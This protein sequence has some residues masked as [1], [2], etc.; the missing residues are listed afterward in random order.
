MK[1]SMSILDLFA[2]FFRRKQ[3]GQVL[4]V[5]T[6]MALV[7]G[8][9]AGLA[10][11]FGDMYLEKAR[12][13]RAVDSLGLRLAGNLPSTTAAQAQSA[14]EIMRA[15][16]PGFMAEYNPGTGYSTT[17]SGAGQTT[18]TMSDSI[19]TLVV[20]VNSAVNNSVNPPLKIVEV[21]AQASR[22]HNTYFLGLAGI[23]Q[24]SLSEKATAERVPC[25]IVLI[26][27]VSG[28]MLGN[29]GSTALPIAVKNFVASFQATEDKD[30]L[31]VVTFS[32]Y[33]KCMWPTN[34]LASPTNLIMAS[35]YFIT[36]VTAFMTNPV[37]SGGIRFTGITCAQEGLRLA[38]KVVDNMLGSISNATLRGKLKVYYI[39]FTDGDFNTTRAY[40]QGTG[41][42]T[43]HPSNSIPWFHSDLPLAC[44][45]MNFAPYT[46][47]Q[48]AN[49][50]NN[51][52]GTTT[53]NLNTTNRFGNYGTVVSNGVSISINTTWTN[54]AGVSATIMASESKSG[55]WQNINDPGAW[56]WPA[57]VPIGNNANGYPGGNSGNYLRT[58]NIWTSTNTTTNGMTN[59][60]LWSNNSS[61]NGSI[62]WQNLLFTN[63]FRATNTPIFTNTNHNMLWWVAVAENFKHAYDF[64]TFVPTP[65][66]W[67]THNPTRHASYPTNS[68]NRNMGTPFI[69][70]YPG[71]R[72]YANIYGIYSGNAT[73]TRAPSD[74]NEHYGTYPYAS[75]R[76]SDYYPSF[77]FGSNPTNILTVTNTTTNYAQL[78]NYTKT[79]GPTL[80]MYSF[81]TGSTTNFTYDSANFPNKN[82]YT[83]I[84][85]EGYWISMM[86][87]WIARNEQNAKIYFVNFSDNN[88]LTEKRNIANDRTGSNGVNVTPFFTGQPSGAFYSTS[89]QA[90]LTAAF[91][92]I[93][94]KI[95]TQL[96]Q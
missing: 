61:T 85:D 53:Y 95:G 68:P 60:S 26:L 46:S 25:I 2:S 79:N 88:R 31:A 75:A 62:A 59:T 7:L 58:A 27:D 30:F 34:Y 37:S 84:A 56:L 11:D 50:T 43:V 18:I 57:G 39:F 44:N 47:V 20:D 66:L 96:T 12:L 13:S 22:K 52:Y 32:T 38:Y 10:I 3:R 49:G 83:A 82:N 23:N 41:Y 91:L 33:A 29:N 8:M 17:S 73:G 87:A 14:L 65:V 70:Y 69:S 63:D 81:R 42:D 72:M 80:S 55:G 45:N 9:F 28:S 74:T 35:N 54:K 21:N 78:V 77:T 90:T 71:G 64:Y 24:I 19:D 76:M 93:A 16:V 94:Q 1:N 48:V 36:P 4:I 92:D 6:G 67:D 15:N 40:V 89:N 5:F 86:Q 51:G